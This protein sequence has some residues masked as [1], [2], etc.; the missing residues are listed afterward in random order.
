MRGVTLS[1]QDEIARRGV[2]R[3]LMEHVDDL[4]V[5]LRNL[6]EQPSAVAVADVRDK[7]APMLAMWETQE[8]VGWPGDE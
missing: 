3:E 8:R 2:L 6:L 7:L 1:D 4:R 5:E